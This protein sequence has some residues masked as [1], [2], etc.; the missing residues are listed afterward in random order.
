MPPATI[1]EMIQ[2]IPPM[3]RFFILGVLLSAFATS[4]GVVAPQH[5]VLHYGDLFKK[6]KLWTFFTTFFYGGGFGQGFVWLLLSIYFTFT[7]VDEY[8]KQR[9]PDQMFMILFSMFSCALVSY[10]YN[11]VSPQGEYYTLLHQFIMCILWISCKLEPTVN[12]NIYGIFTIASGYLPFL[13]LV[14][15]MLSG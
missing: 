4:N 1:G 11:K 15:D 5:L 9:R 8:Y 10:L 2:R 13:Y 12:V 6:L 3:T 7:R 14:Y